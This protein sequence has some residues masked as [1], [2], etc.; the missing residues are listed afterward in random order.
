MKR[1]SLA[2][3]LVTLLSVELGCDASGAI[4]S[5]V[6]GET[7]TQP[8]T[9]ELSVFSKEYTPP[10]VGLPDRTEGGGTR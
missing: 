7:L 1:T 3:A 6:N 5:T 8:T 4:A 9:S 2:L 10:I